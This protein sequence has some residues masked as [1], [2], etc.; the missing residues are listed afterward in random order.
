MYIRITDVCY[1]VCGTD[2]VS[3]DKKLVEC[4]ENFCTDSWQDAPECFDHLELTLSLLPAECDDFQHAQ[5][6][7]CT[8]EE[9]NWDLYEE[10]PSGGSRADR[11]DVAALRGRIGGIW[12]TF[13][14]AAQRG[15]RVEGQLGDYGWVTPQHRKAVGKVMTNFSA[16]TEEVAD[17]LVYSHR[18][19]FDDTVEV[20]E[21]GELVLYDD[22]LPE[23]EEEA[24]RL[25]E[26]IEIIE[27]L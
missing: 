20:L 2:K 10:Y 14:D 25:A 8:C 11:K 3:C 7:S 23:E 13:F 24:Q 9:P 16:T 5:A 6:E 27:D 4:M 15:E 1:Q 18:I 22:D 12:N 17:M 26:E 21:G 19:F